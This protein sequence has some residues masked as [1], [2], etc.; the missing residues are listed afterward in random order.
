MDTAG[1][2]KV[3]GEVEKIG[4][5]LTKQRLADADLSLI[6]LDQSRPLTQEDRNI[7]AKVQK[8]KSLILVNKTDLPCR[9]AKEELDSALDALP[10][11]RISALTGEGIDGLRRAIRDQVMA[12]D[13]DLTFSGVTPNLRH[14]EALEEAAK[15]FSDASRNARDGRPIELI[16]VDLNSG[17]EALGEI[18]GETTNEEILD[19]IF[20]EFCLGK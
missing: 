14:K 17:L 13:L 18:I 9:I 5:R 7:I 11:V 16:A 20:S 15:C 10:V 12:G 6:V 4:I 8:G 3:K 2:R 1:F 19:R